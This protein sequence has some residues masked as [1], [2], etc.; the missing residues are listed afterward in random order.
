M[1]VFALP[2][3]QK[4]LRA[5]TC[6]NSLDVSEMFVSGAYAMRNVIVQYFEL[7]F[8][9]INQKLD[10]GFSKSLFTIKIDIFPLLQDSHSGL[11]S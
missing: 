1:Y 9:M 2:D 4:Q 11:L 8:V 10:F 7:V 3:I 6:L 5:K